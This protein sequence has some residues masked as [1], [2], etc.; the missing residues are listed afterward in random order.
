LVFAEIESAARRAPF[1][2]IA[3]ATCVDLWVSTPTMMAV[4]FVLS[5]GPSLNDDARA[6]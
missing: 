1:K 5:I 6:P 2:F 3:T 4:E